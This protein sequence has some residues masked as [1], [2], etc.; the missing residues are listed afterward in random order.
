MTPVNIKTHLNYRISDISY[1]K[2]HDLSNLRV[3]T[4]GWNAVIVDNIEFHTQSSILKELKTQIPE[5]LL[6]LQV[7]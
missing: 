4:E 1:A 5:Q 6:I 7:H 3:G 2:T